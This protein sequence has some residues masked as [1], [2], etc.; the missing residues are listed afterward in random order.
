MKVIKIDKSDKRADTRSAVRSQETVH[1]I[2]CRSDDDGANLDGY[3]VRH[4]KVE[5]DVYLHVKL[6]EEKIVSLENERAN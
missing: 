5:K 4:V 6:L 1:Y 3:Y 2:I